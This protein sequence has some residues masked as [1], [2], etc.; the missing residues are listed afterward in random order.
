MKLMREFYAG[1]N[2]LQ[3][4][5]GQ[6]RRADGRL[7]SQGDQVRCG[8]KGLK[9]RIGG[10]ARQGA[11]A[12]MG[13]VPQQIAGGEIYPALEKGTIDAAEWVGP[14]D[15]EKL[16]FNKVASSTTTPAGGRAARAALFINIKAWSELPKEYQ[17]I[18]EAACAQGEHLHARE[19]RRAESGR[20]EAPGGK[21][22][23]I[24]GVPQGRHGCLLQGRA[25]A[26]R[27]NHGEEREVQECLRAD[28]P[29]PR[30]HVLWFRFTENPYDDF[31]ASVKK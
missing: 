18:F 3:L 6:H 8:L 11:D 9:M 10:F 17:A 4:P 5:D 30:R 2:I 19:V 26:V 23:P 20:A 7:V 22:H 29:V 31:M 16:G 1:Y 15:D 13:G 21:R 24:Q 14:Y 28:D 12:G 27:G 25:G